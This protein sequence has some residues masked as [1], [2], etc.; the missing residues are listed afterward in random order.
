MVRK[1]KLN[2]IVLLASMIIAGYLFFIIVPYAEMH[3]FLNENE[4]PRHEE[5]IKYKLLLY[6]FMISYSILA[7][8]YIHKITFFRTISYP[9]YIANIYFG[10]CLFMIEGGGAALWLILPTL[11]FPIIALP[12]SFL[13]GVMDDYK[14]IKNSRNNMKKQIH[15]ITMETLKKLEQ[16]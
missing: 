1:H 7:S 10:L 4:Q 8:I 16:K 5:A 15:Q 14:Y 13:N 12:I 11:I 2:I 6:P 9:L 3:G